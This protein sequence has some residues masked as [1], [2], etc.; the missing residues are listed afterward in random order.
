M[1]DNLYGS[2]PNTYIHAVQPTTALTTPAWAS[3]CH[4]PP[5]PGKPIITDITSDIVEYTATYRASLAGYGTD[6]TGIEDQGASPWI[7]ALSRR[8]QRRGIMLKR[9]PTEPSG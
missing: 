3:G 8:R 2:N 6:D 1:L 7:L 5:G 4:L 9:R